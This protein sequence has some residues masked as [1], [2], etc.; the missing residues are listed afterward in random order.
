M[1]RFQKPNYRVP[2][3]S[4]Q[5]QWAGGSMPVAAADEE[6]RADFIRKTY[7]HVAGAIAA[8][9]GL[10]TVYFVAAPQALQVN[11]AQALTANKWIWL[12][13]LGLWFGAGYLANALTAS[14]GSK[15]KQYAGLGLYV[16]VMAVVMLP[17]LTFLKFTG[18]AGLIGQAAILTLVIFGSLTVFVMVT[19][20]NFSFLR[21]II[22]IGMGVAMAVILASI[23]FEFNLGLWLTIPVI[24][25]LCGSIL[26]QTSSVMNEFPVGFHV[27]AAL[28]LFSTVA[29]LFLWILDLFMHLQS[30]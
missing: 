4:A 12:L 27:A 1:S 28:G 13:V 3:S 20:A 19:G 5:S 30:E 8:M 6:T 14:P 26:Y 11:I 22:G 7:L 16:V 25:L 9:I 21:G 29:V 17:I 10:L 15:G 24:A 23:L 2:Q 18:Q